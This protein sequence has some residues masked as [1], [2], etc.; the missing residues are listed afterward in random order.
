MGPL[1]N[2]LQDQD[3]DQQIHVSLEGRKEVNPAEYVGSDTR[4]AR[5]L[6]RVQP[7]H[8]CIRCNLCK[9]KLP[10]KGNTHQI[11]ASLVALY[12]R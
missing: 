9:N 1:N 7:G 2:G 4:D 10:G 11:H 3:N 12:R 8:S 5:W 6:Y